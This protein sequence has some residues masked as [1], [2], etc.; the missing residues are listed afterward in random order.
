V[1][2]QLTIPEAAAALGVTEA[3]LRQRI[4]RGKIEVTREGSRV[5]V[6]LAN[7]PVDVETKHDMFDRHDIGQV[8]IQQVLQ[9]P[10]DPDEEASKSKIALEGEQFAVAALERVL[11]DSLVRASTAEQA[12]AMWQ[13]R[14][15]NL[16]TQVEQLLALPA[17]EEEP[18]LGRRWWQVWHRRD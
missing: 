15:R 8:P 1:S 4:A 6:H 2:R 13:E 16:E 18:A 3:A 5:Y 11:R 17:H 7:D 10:T 14:A 9:Q 12:A